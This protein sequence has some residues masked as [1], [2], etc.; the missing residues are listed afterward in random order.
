MTPLS[1]FTRGALF[2]WSISFND[3]FDIQRIFVWEVQEGG[4]GGGD[5]GL[6]KTL[7]KSELPINVVTI[8]ENLKSKLH[9]KLNP[10]LSKGL[11]KSLLLAVSTMHIER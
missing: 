9:V 1:D 10:A 7:F 4:G 8:C 2:G 6:G 3:G 5:T 11:T